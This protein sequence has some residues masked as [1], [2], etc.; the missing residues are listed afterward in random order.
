MI[1]NP[2]KVSDPTA[3]RGDYYRDGG[4]KYLHPPLSSVGDTWDMRV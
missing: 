1:A 4:V 2:D 3:I